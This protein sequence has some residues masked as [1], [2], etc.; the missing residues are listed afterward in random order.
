MVAGPNGSGKSTL[1][2]RLRTLVN[3]GVYVNSDEIE[4]S[5][6]NRGLIDLSAYLLK[7]SDAAFQTFVK[8]SG[9]AEFVGKR[10][11]I[12]RDNFIVQRAKRINSY[13]A[14][15]VAD[16]LRHRLLRK[17][18]SFTFETVMSHSDKV[19][20]LKSARS[21]GYRTYLYFVSTENPKINIGRVASRVKKG[22]HPVPRNKIISR[23][24]KSI[25]LLPAAIKRTNRAYIFDNSHSDVELKLEVT[26]A[27]L[28]RAH[29]TEIP[30][31]TAKFVIDP[32]A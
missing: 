24:Y 25:G 12:V 2:S 31:W 8:A 26:D 19:A 5:I 15:C 13:H 27:T 14:A 20:L 22:G 29:S 6:H 18:T 1:I 7:A 3:L 23:Y 11:L 21:A 30:E 16:F 17:R 9:W 4:Y 28:I 10:D 32:L